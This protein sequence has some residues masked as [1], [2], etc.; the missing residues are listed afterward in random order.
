MKFAPRI[1]YNYNK[2]LYNT[3][4]VTIGR[5]VLQGDS[6]SP[7]L[8]NMCFNTLMVTIKK[9]QI[10]CLGYILSQLQTDKKYSNK[11]LGH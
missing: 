7:L 3:P 5:G 4:A 9:D 8:F 10:K 1:M 11:L 6:L 2:H